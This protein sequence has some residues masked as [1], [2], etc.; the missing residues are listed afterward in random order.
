MLTVTVLPPATLLLLNV[1]LP[2]AEV[3]EGVRVKVLE[4]LVTPIDV[5]AFGGPENVPVKFAPVPPGVMVKVFEPLV[6][7]IEVLDCG[8]APVWKVPMDCCA[9][10]LVV[11]VNVFDGRLFVITIEPVLAVGSA[12]N[13]PS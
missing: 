6:I 7:A 2:V 13:V 12:E 9:E 8:I 5:L 4:P 3:P 1:A 10:A 11:R